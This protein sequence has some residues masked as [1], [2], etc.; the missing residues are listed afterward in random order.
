MTCS[1]KTKGKLLARILQ[2]SYSFLGDD[3]IASIASSR[4][5]FDSVER[6]DLDLLVTANTEYSQVTTTPFSPSPDDNPDDIMNRSGRS[7][8]FSK[9]TE[10]PNTGDQTRADPVQR[11]AP[12]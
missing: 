7:V 4:Y 5:T 3:E 2:F 6:P 1:F 9:A 8:I 10:N 12:I 11:V